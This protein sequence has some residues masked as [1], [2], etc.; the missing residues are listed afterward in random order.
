MKNGM[1]DVSQKKSV[2][3]YA[4]AEGEISLKKNTVEMIK[5]G[6]VEKGDVIHTARIAG[7]QAAKKTSEVIPLCHQIPLDFAKIHFEILNEK[8]ICVSEVKATHRTGVEME[9]LVGVCTSLL[10][11][12]D[13]V[14]SLEKENSNYPKT[15][16]NKVKVLEK[17][18]D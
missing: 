9:A 1:V 2:S 5:D 15:S 3:R 18:K 11:I 12:W 14:K 8:I 4:K 16:I 6:K 13:M 10:T 7:I 17:T